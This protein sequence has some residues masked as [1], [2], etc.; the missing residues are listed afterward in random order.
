MAG[1][2]GLVLSFD[3]GGTKLRGGWVSRSGSVREEVT[4]KVHQQE[5]FRGLIQLFSDVHQSLSDTGRPKR[6]SVASAGP[7]DPVRG[8]LLDPT[9]FFTNSRSWGVVPLKRELQRLFRCPVTIE[10]DAAAAVIGELKKGGWGRKSQNLVA[11]T[12]GTGVGIGVVANGQL[13]RAG[14]NLHPEFSHVPI[15]RGNREYP[16]GCGSYGCIEAYLA[17]THFTRRLQ[18]SWGARLTSEEFVERARGGHKGIKREFEQYGQA[19]AQAVRSLAVTFAPELVVLS[20]GFSNAS[21][22]FLPAA[23]QDLPDLLK[24][25]RKG[26]DLTPQ[27]RVSKIGDKAALI[28]AAQ[29]ATT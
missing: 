29:L 6:V 17:G 22:L 5:G 19:L 16:C 9:N 28:G 10:N 13:I 26:V 1:S 7:L 20:G 3:L 18:K 23:R 27:I 24:R 11:M 4:L 12:L 8:V 14:R 15:Q 2:A 21:D 25:Y